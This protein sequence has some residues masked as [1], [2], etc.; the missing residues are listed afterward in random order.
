M[1]TLLRLQRLIPAFGLLSNRI[2]YPRL[3]TGLRV[4][5]T[6]DGQFDYGSGVSLG[7]GTRVDLL[8]ESR[9]I[10][11]DNIITGRNVYIRLEKGDRQSIGDRTSLQDACR[12]YGDVRI[13]RGCIFA[14][15]VFLSSY[16]H[17]FGAKPHLPI[18]DQERLE[19]AT[20][21]PIRIF[22]DC[23]LGINVFVS[24]G[25]TIGRGC[26]IGANAVVTRDLPPYSIAGGVPARVIRPRLAFMAKSRI[27][28]FRA[29]DSP[30]FYDGFDLR[31]PDGKGFRVTRGDFILVLVKENA[32]AVRL[33]VNSQ[34][35]EIT[36]ASQTQA[37]AGENTIV[38]FSTSSPPSHFLEFHASERCEI[39]WAELV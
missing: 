17:V 7:E 25:T 10:L 9:L 4:E 1:H 8:P 22:D 26:V 37:V 2:R 19:P 15:N 30:Y 27:E 5:I 29:E 12:I 32:R 33:C 6:S 36:F 16:A 18:L 28:A 23:W 13:G 14:P 3:W 24:P 34:D 38:E 11:G 31:P 35:A 20:S 21:K 39:R